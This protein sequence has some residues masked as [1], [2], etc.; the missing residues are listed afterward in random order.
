MSLAMAGLCYSTLIIGV[1]L[2]GL[3]C[4]AA[5]VRGLDTGCRRCEKRTHYLAWRCHFVPETAQKGS[6]FPNSTQERV[7]LD[8]DGS[9]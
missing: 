6:V 2:A 3:L 7:K 5:A 1:C 8:K 9:W 4:A